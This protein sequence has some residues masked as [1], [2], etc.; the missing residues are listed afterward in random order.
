[1][2]QLPQAMQYVEIQSSSSEEEASPKDEV[3]PLDVGLSDFDQYGDD[4]LGRR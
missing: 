2:A 4:P 3:T 1:M